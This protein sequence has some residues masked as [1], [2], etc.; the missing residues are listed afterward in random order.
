MNDTLDLE[1]LRTFSAVARYG[2]F[3]AA[4]EHLN[5]SPSAVS[6]HIRLL[7]DRVGSRL[8]E[9]D[10]QGVVLTPTGRRFLLE[11]TELLEVHDRIV[12]RLG[13]PKAAGRVRFGVSEEYAK[14]LLH[15]LL[16]DFRT[17]QPRVELEVT[18]AS[19]LVLA[20]RLREGGLD[21][22]VLI[23]APGDAPPTPAI[24]FGTTQPVWVGAS[25][26]PLAADAPVPLALH[27]PGCPYRALAIDALARTGR[28]WTA[29]LTSEGAAALEAAIESGLAIGILDRSRVGTA[30]AVLGS[31]QGLP[32]LPAQDVLLA[33][34]PSESSAATE[35]LAALIRERFYL[36]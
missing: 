24:R 27:G 11:A 34:S 32:P 4:S 18:T 1:L 19:S 21:L 9:R 31:D 30:L 16:A 25:G 6:T 28:A 29:V 35:L 8:L 23:R 3:R 36:G 7:E 17:E 5:R 20:D 2:R 15:G 13:L 14:S 33:T 22:A 26:R 10:N 12:A